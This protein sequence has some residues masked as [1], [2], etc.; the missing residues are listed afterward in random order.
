MQ[1]I[2]PGLGHRTAAHEVIRMDV[3]SYYLAAERVILDPMLPASVDAIDE[4]ALHFTRDRA[5]ACAD[6]VV[7][8]PGRDALASVPDR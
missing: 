4:T 7:R 2:A 8:W 1:E 5:L 6:A 3:S